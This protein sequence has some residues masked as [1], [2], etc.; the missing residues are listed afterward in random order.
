MDMNV[1]QSWVKVGVGPN[2]LPL[3]LITGKNGSEVWCEIFRG[4]EKGAPDKYIL[5]HNL[6]NGMLFIAEQ[7]M[8]AWME[9]DMY[10]IHDVMNGN[11][12]S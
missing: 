3:R 8:G 1:Y 4:F 12:M 5:C 9:V 2:N 6:L 10:K 7:R 11:R